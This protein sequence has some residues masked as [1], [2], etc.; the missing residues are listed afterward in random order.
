M[1]R[2]ADAVSAQPRANPRRRNRAAA[3]RP[4]LDHPNAPENI[5]YSATPLSVRLEYAAFY[6]GMAAVL[7]IT[8][9]QA[10]QT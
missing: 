1:D 6:R 2:G 7:A 3:T 4:R 10:H 8:T 5:A 9:Y